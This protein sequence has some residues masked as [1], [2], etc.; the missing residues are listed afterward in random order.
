M[1]FGTG[2]SC[3]KHPKG[4]SGKRNLSPFLLPQ[5]HGA[6]ACPER[7]RRDGFDTAALDWIKKEVDVN[8]V[9]GQ[10]PDEY[11]RDTRLPKSCG[12]Q[13]DTVRYDRSGKETR[14]WSLDGAW[15][16]TLESDDLE[17][18]NSENSIEKLTVCYQYWRSA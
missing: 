15:T 16:K 11:M 10:L 6:G 12:G 3:A 2:T 5:G 9:T 13:L 8:E 18:G 4:R 14:R 7:R 17:G 1:P